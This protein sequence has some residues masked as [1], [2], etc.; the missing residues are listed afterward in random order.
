MG[1]RVTSA[2]YWSRADRNDD[3]ERRDRAACDVAQAFFFA[4]AGLV[5]AAFAGPSFLGAGFSFTKT[6]NGSE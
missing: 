2:R 4:G 3:D 6:W 1:A 5:G